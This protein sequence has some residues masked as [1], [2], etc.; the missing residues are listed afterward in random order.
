M[1]EH[2]VFPGEQL[3]SF[4]CHTSHRLHDIVL[5]LFFVAHGS[6]GMLTTSKIP[7]GPSGAIDQL[8]KNAATPFAAWNVPTPDTTVPN[9][10]IAVGII[11]EAAILL[12]MSPATAAPAT[13]MLFAAPSSA[14]VEISEVLIFGL[15]ER[16]KKEGGLGR[17]NSE[18]SEH[19]KRDTT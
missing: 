5:D 12:P 14:F 9:V 13:P 17:E 7:A 11:A 19:R 4:P 16:G 3:S 8:C 15:K 2:S 6:S 18:P 1:S 10:L